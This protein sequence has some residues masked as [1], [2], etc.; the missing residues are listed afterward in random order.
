MFSRAL[1]LLKVVVMVSFFF[2]LTGCDT[3]KD[4]LTTSTA[5]QLASFDQTI[6]QHEQLQARLQLNLDDGLS[7]KLAAT[8]EINAKFK[9]NMAFAIAEAKRLEMHDLSHA[10]VFYRDEFLTLQSFETSRLDHWSVI[11]TD[12]EQNFF[13]L[14]NQRYFDSF[15]QAHQQLTKLTLGMDEHLRN[16]RLEMKARLDQRVIEPQLKQRLWT[17][18]DKDYQ[19]QIGFARDWFKYFNEL[20]LQTEIYLS[21]S[22]RLRCCYTIDA[23]NAKV[24]LTYPWVG[25]EIHQVQLK[26]TRAITGD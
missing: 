2:H 15:V 25:E 24:I 8:Q 7:A 16:A 20:N 3:V 6:A 23:A 14:N 10:L 19:S 21:N 26:M 13:E 12:P 1:G 17:L 11:A 18:L 5:K 9:D 22:E 4:W